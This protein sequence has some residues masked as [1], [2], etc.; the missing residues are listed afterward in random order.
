MTLMFEVITNVGGNEDGGRSAKEPCTVL[1]GG[2]DQVVKRIQELKAM[3]ILNCD[4][5]G[6]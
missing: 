6:Q 1:N 5:S 4:Q 3:T 2:D